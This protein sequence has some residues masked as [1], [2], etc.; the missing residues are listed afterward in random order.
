M[1]PHPMQNQPQP[2]STPRRRVREAVGYYS[3]E[4]RAWVLPGAM[5]NLVPWQVDTVWCA[6]LEE[7]AELCDAHAAK[8]AALRAF[9]R[10]ESTARF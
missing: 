6:S 9:E 8:C 5:S 3:R 10:S 7:A 4:S 2:R 1:I